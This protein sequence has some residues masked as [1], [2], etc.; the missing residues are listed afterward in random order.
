M[1][2]RKKLLNRSEARTMLLLE[3]AATKYGVA[4]HTKVRVA[5]VL[6]V[7]G[8]GV[9]D[10]TFSY[11]LK[12][13][14]DFVLTDEDH[15]PLFAVE[16][17]GPTHET[18]QVQANDRRKNELCQRLGLPLARVRDEHTFQRARGLNYLTWL[19]E[20]FFA[21]KSLSDAQDRGDFPLDE[22]PD[23]LS[24]VS[25]P[26]LQGRFPLFLSAAARTRLMRLDRSGVLASAVPI[27]FRGTDENGVAGALVL[28]RTA[29]GKLLFAEGDVYLAG[30][31]ISPSEAAEEIAVV[32]LAQVAMDYEADQ[33]VAI[34]QAEAQQRIAR[35]IKARDVDGSFSGSSHVLDFSV[36]FSSID[37]REAWTIGDVGRSEKATIVRRRR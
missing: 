21:F 19:A 18:A 11:A 28:T 15:M 5:D 37:G 32:A 7:I 29:D 25:I 20:V 14:F 2:R 17:D 33:P 35:F 9:D 3:G 16:F 34:T 1:D 36:S 8:S 6:D 24:F 26:S 27:S 10:A 12:A 30:F 31:G 4:V 13:H 22:P 23:P